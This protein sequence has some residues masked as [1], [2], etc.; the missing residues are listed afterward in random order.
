MRPRL[1]SQM[2]IAALMEAVIALRE[3]VVAELKRAVRAY[4]QTIRAE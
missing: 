4:L 3:D 1:W 2:S